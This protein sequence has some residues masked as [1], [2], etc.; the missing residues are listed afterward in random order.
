MTTETLGEFKLGTWCSRG[1]LNLEQSPSEES[2][3]LREAYRNLGLGEDPEALEEQCDGL[4]D[5][6]QDKQLQMMAQ[7]NTQ[8]KL[9][10]REEAEEQETET[11][12][13]PS[14]VCYRGCSAPECLIQLKL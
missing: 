14:K 11:E 13:G 12:Q 3:A 6:L 1:I 9:Q 10:L 2:D 5:A 7:E 8:L 4:E